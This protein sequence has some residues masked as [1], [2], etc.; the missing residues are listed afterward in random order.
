MSRA[1]QPDAS[2]QI[3]RSL[4]T[5]LRAARVRAGLTVQALALR[6]E[7]SQ[8][9]LSQM[10]NGKV[11]P[12]IATLYRLASALDVSPQELLPDARAEEVV[13]VRAGG[14]AARPIEERPDAA[15]ARVL[16]GAPGRVL[17]VQEVTIEP[18]QEAGGWFEHDGEEFLYV[19]EGAI[20]LEV[21]RTPA[22]QLGPGD[23]AWYES[24]RPHRWTVVGGAGARVLAV[25][26]LPP[27]ALV[28]HS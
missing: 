28:I 3:D 23:A 12:S 26:G 19:L 11:S 1:E 15:L 25:S 8:P 20:A 13:V 18:G 17:Q 2:G 16:V 14:G 10:E 9:H 22:A 24:R 21:G 5:A 27:Q 7:I 4:G 6:A